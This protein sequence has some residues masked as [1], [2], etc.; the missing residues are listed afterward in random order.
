MSEG[1]VPGG[2]PESEEQLLPVQPLEA[3][4][5]TALPASGIKLVSIS[6]KQP[7]APSTA[8]AANDPTR[9]GAF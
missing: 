2:V 6:V 3:S 1:Q 9:T 4:K 8:S 5:W 7:A